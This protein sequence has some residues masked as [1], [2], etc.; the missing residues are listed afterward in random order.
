MYILSLEGKHPKSLIE[1]DIDITLSTVCDNT[2]SEFIFNNSGPGKYYPGGPECMYKGKEGNH[3][4]QLINY[5]N[6]ALYYS[7][8]DSFRIKFE[9]SL[10]RDS[11]YHFLVEQNGTWE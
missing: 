8:N 2:R 3:W 10:K 9:Q 6:D 4:I 7:N 11:I 1:A 5:V